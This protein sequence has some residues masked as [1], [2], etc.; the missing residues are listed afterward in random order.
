MESEDLSVIFPQ[1][2]KRPKSGNCI[3]RVIPL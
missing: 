1:K 3:N 2:G